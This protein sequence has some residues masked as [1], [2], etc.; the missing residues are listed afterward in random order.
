MRA[1]YIIKS[2]LDKLDPYVAVCFHELLAGK[3]LTAMNQRKQRAVDSNNWD[4][5]HNIGLAVELYK[6]NKFMIEKGV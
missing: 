6:Q 5:Y 2:V 3:S 4:K 1:T